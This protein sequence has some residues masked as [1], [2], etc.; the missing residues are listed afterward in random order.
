[1]QPGQH[2]G[3]QTQY[4]GKWWNF[5]EE[6]NMDNVIIYDAING[7]LNECETVEGGVNNIQETLSASSLI[8]AG[9]VIRSAQSGT[10]NTTITLS[11]E[12][13]TYTVSIPISALSDVRKAFLTHSIEI[14]SSDSPLP[15]GRD[16][17]VVL[18][19]NSI[20]VIFYQAGN[21][22]GRKY[23]ATISGDWRIIEF[24]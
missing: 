6:E 9:S 3:G 10:A 21:S 12:S 16:K 5:I 13:K 19:Q 20:D 15:V 17:S 22:G 1:M 11:N 4:I 18:K 8:N 24:Y 23:H 7:I 14:T 2:I